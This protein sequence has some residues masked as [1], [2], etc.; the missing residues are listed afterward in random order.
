MKTTPKRRL[1]LRGTSSL[2]LWVWLGA[3]CAS[4]AY[5]PAAHPGNAPPAMTASAALRTIRECLDR[6]ARPEVNGC[7]SRYRDIRATFN[8]LAFTEVE[9]CE[10]LRYQWAPKS[11]AFAFDEIPR[12]VVE[13]W[14]GRG[15]GYYSSPGLVVWWENHDLAYARA[16][17]DA[18]AAVKYY[19]SG[20]DV[21]ADAAAFARFQQEARAWRALSSRPPLPEEVRRLR[22]LAEDAFRGKDLEGA[23]ELYEQGLLLQPLWPEGQF[24]AALL[25]GELGVYGQAVIRMKRYLELS[26]DAPD[27]QAARDQLTIWQAKVGR[28]R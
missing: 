2:L 28:R 24:N 11:V 20:A 13:S 1:L 21:A 23:V 19:R 27:A 7:T 8:D 25:Y 6:A 10:N 17:V 9:K 15:S 5:A 16:F 4:T 14:S 3:G 26:P 22:M 12:L 18:V